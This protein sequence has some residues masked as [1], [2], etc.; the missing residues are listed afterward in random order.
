[1]RD[2]FPWYDAWWLNRFVRA[3]ELIDGYTNAQ[4]P[5]VS[6]LK[7][8]RL[9]D[10]ATARDPGFVLA[11]CYAARTHDLLVSVPQANTATNN[12]TNL[13]NFRTWFFFAIFCLPVILN[14][15]H[16]Q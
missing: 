3:K 16:R 2:R 11:Y 9:L 8:L 13:V 1:M 10:D 4:D 7:A 14:I 15:K 6:L 12:A 5:K